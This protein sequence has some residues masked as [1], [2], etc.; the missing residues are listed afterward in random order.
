VQM[1]RHPRFVYAPEPAFVGFSVNLIRDKLERSTTESRE[2]SASLSL[3][4]LTAILNSRFAGNWFEHHAKRRG[5]HLDITGGTLKRFPL[6]PESS[7][8]A[9]RIDFLAN[10]RMRREGQFRTTNGPEIGREIT[11]LEREIDELIDEWYS[12]QHPLRR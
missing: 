12:T 7:G 1:G 4:A 2:V 3:P 10:L 8:L 5:V 11:A 6:P 9:K